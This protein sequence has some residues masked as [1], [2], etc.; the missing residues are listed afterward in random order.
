MSNGRGHCRTVL[1]YG[2]SQSH[3]ISNPLVQ[4]TSAEEVLKLESFDTQRLREDLT[5]IIISLWKIVLHFDFDK[6]PA[7]KVSP[8][9][10]WGLM[11]RG[12]S[13]HA[14][15]AAC[16]CL[17]SELRKTL[18]QQGRRRE[19]K[20]GTKPASSLAGYRSS[21]K[22]ASPFSPPDF[23]PTALPSTFIEA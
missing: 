23:R 21:S 15:P 3:W 13:T 14:N 10:Q 4:P 7:S 1:I 20:E 2:M 19:C 11:T 22:R 8:A 12:A 16:R 5:T 17:S 18:K 9:K 6:T